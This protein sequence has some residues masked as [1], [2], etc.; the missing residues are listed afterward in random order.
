MSATRIVACR[1]SP[2]LLMKDARLGFNW[3]W[4]FGGLFAVTFYLRDGRQYAQPMS[5]AGYPNVLQ[6]IVVKARQQ[7]CVDRYRW[8]RNASAY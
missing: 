3:C 1:R 5:R 6:Y 4:F 8:T 2:L 7:V